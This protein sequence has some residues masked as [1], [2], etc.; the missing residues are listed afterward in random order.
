MLSFTI[1]FEMRARL[2]FFGSGLFAFFGT[3]A[4]VFGVANLFLNSN[5]IE[6][7]SESA[8]PSR[9]R[10]EVEK[11]DDDVRIKFPGK[12]TFRLAIS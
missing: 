11:N 9:S 4:V 5:D 1:V 8:S 12:E 7:K 3:L 10:R 6:I 2:K